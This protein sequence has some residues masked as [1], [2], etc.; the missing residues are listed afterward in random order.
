MK[1]R[2]HHIHHFEFKTRCNENFGFAFVRA[3]FTALL[4]A[5]F[6]RAQARGADCDHAAAA[7]FARL[8][9]IHCRLRN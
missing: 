2:D 9:R 6:E 8:D 3:Q 4:C 5:T 1:V 7:R